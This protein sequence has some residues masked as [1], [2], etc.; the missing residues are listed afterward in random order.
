MQHERDRHKWE[1]RE[2]ERENIPT[3]YRNLYL[4]KYARLYLFS[5]RY[6]FLDIDM[7]TAANAANFW[8]DILAAVSA[9]SF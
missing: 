6:L 9:A 5:K 3:F 8:F 4:A 1:E 7:Q 2:G